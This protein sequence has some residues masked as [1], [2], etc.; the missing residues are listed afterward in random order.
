MLYIMNSEGAVKSVPSRVNQGSVNVN[1][2]ILLAP[3]PSS[4]VVC[5]AIELPNKVKIKPKPM[6]NVDFAIDFIED[7]DGR[8][9]NA[10]RY[11]LP[12]VLTQYAGTAKLTFIL[13]TKDGSLPSD[14]CLLAINKTTSYLLETVDESDFTI[15]GGYLS[16]AETAAAD[17]E[18]AANNAQT[19]AE[20]ARIGAEIAQGYAV[21]PPER[22]GEIND[23]SS[24]FYQNN[25]KYFR[26]QAKESA[27]SAQFAAET[28]RAEADALNR[29]RV[30]GISVI[31][32]SENHK[33][34]IS[35]QGT[36]AEGNENVIIGTEQVIDLPLEAVVVNGE[37]DK[38]TKEVVLKLQNGNEIRFT[39]PTLVDGLVKEYNNFD[40]SFP[41]VYAVG[42]RN[43]PQDPVIISPEYDGIPSAIVR[44]DKNGQFK[45][46]APTDNKHAVNKEYADTKSRI[47][48]RVYDEDSGEATEE[49]IEELDV[50]GYATKD[51]IEA[52]Y[53]NISE[54]D[55]DVRDL[56][57][58]V[59][60]KM[61]NTA[62]LPDDRNT[63]IYRIPACVLVDGVPK[64]VNKLASA[65]NWQQG[66]IPVRTT[67]GALYVGQVSAN[68]H[69]AHKAYVDNAVAGATLEFTES[70][71]TSFEHNIPGGVASNAILNSV[72][73]ANERDEYNNVLKV[74]ALET[75]DSLD[76]NGANFSTFEIPSAL[77]NA[78]G[79]SYGMQWTKLD[80]DKKRFEDRGVTLVLDGTTY[81]ASHTDNVYGNRYFSI[82]L[83]K[84]K[85]AK[86]GNANAFTFV[87]SHFVPTGKYP[88]NGDSI[89]QPAGYLYYSSSDWQAAETNDRDR[90]ILFSGNLGFTTL[91]DFNAWLKEQYDNGT[92]VTFRYQSDTEPVVVDLSSHLTDYK[93]FKA[94]PI[95]ENCGVQFN[96]SD[97]VPVTSTITY[98]R[99]KS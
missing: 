41:K 39:V 93:R 88:A 31:H 36:D 80:F 92:P 37:Y 9:Y 81:K 78:C 50:N 29:Q 52:V 14:E 73:G 72:E 95:V 84:D 25:A 27:T 94:I 12:G 13:T 71:Q 34:S 44:R 17:A 57:N 1:E 24:L 60:T 87:S 20:E 96:C 91:D 58:E 97:F 3:F 45:I 65:Q 64:Y 15:I 2:I 6:A 40:S 61:P 47:V 42:A 30:A 70:T 10:W 98:L 56:G 48:R 77:R 66:D 28:V 33:I 54:V 4:T 53:N 51:N 83:P 90:L 75:V 22:N 67:G 99:R 8:Y 89:T 68:N 46:P 76:T 21:G 85:Y 5:F 18:L 79:E 49:F 69:A 74:G 86:K 11:V 55:T 23:R 82:N 19:A 43:A 62:E 35:L 59:A 38:E 16:A 26:D 32:N 63:S 7:A